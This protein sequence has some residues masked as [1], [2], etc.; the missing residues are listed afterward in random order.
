[1]FGVQRFRKSPAACVGDDDDDDFERAPAED[2]R[3]RLC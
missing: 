2:F 1:L 3:C